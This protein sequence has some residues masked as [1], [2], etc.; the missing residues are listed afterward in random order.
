MARKNSAKSAYPPPERLSCPEAEQAFSWL[1]MLLDAYYIADAGIHEQIRRDTVKHKRRLA[2]AKGC[3]TCCKTHVTI[4]VYPLELVGLFWY[5]SDVIGPDRKDAVLGQL[6][7]YVPGRGCPFLV[8]ESCAVHPMR[9]LACRFF[10]VFNTACAPGEDPFY[11]RRND[12]MTPD[13]KLKDKALASLLPYHGIHLRQQRKE[14]MQNGFFLRYVKNLQDIN[15]T[16]VAFQIRNGERTPLF[17]SVA[18]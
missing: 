15:W 1:P 10:N 8:D 13:E 4:P 9:P 5:L 2:C 16:K 12:V 14:A 7:S 18:E 6:E 11:T 3:S 17:R